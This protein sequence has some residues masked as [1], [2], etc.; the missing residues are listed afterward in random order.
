MN[1][2]AANSL[3]RGL[4]GSVLSIGVIYGL[5]LLARE[6][7]HTYNGLERG[8]YPPI[9]ERDIYHM[10]LE[11]IEAGRPVSDQVMDLATGLARYQVDDPNPQ[12]WHLDERF[13][14]FTKHEEGDLTTS[15]KGRH[16]SP[17]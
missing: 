6:R 9:S 14:H 3:S 17:H 15:T 8:G 16:K 7:Q 12:H 10:F 11:A 2:L 13:S 4:A 1:G 5:G